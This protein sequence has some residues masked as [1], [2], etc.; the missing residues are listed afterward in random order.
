MII[1]FLFYKTFSWFVKY[2]SWLYKLVANNM[3]EVHIISISNQ[4]L[5]ITIEL[6]HYD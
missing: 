5:L 6:I 1:P 3:Y 4:I 2:R